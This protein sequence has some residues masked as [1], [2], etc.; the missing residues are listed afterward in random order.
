[1]KKKK[2]EITLTKQEKE[3]LIVNAHAAINARTVFYEAL[4]LL[5]RN[6][7]HSYLEIRKKLDDGTLHA[8]FSRDELQEDMIEKLHD[9]QYVA[10]LPEEDYKNWFTSH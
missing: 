6:D 4:K 2:K 10:K 9:P 1:M 3:R 7:Y 8:V 5:E